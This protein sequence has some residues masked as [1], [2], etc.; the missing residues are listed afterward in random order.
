MTPNSSIASFFPDFRLLDLEAGGVRFSGVVGGEGPPVL[1]LH[2]YPQTHIAWRRVA[3]TL[4]QRHTLVIPDLPGYGASRPEQMDPRWTKRRAGEALVALMAALDHDRFAVVG[5]DRGARVGYRLTL[6]HPNQVSAYASLA[7]V[8]TLDVMTGINFGFAMKNFHWFFLAQ[9]ADLPERMLAAD[10]DAFIDRA[11]YGMTGGR[12][13]I[14]D[15][16]LDAYRLAFRDPA[17]RHAICEDY[18]AAAAEDLALDRADREAGRK[19]SCPVMVLWPAADW[20]SDGPTP[21]D[22]WR[23]WA[24]DVKGQATAGGHLQAED[25]PD[26]VLARLGPF[27]S[28]SQN[29]GFQEK[30]RTS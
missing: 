28:D 9:K 30:H 1:L 10:P 27:L 26:E 11:L 13:V 23:R 5:H 17:V 3:P 21:V 2:G 25:A 29:A 18:R 14:G 19:L 15:A 24:N 4:A 7:V 6:D 8:P 16:A 12:D 22:I 20:P